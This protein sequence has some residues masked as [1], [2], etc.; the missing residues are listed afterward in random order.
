[1]SKKHPMTEYFKWGI[2]LTLPAALMTFLFVKT[3][4]G[5]F[6]VF[7]LGLGLCVG[8]LFLFRLINLP[9]S[10]EEIDAL[11]EEEIIKSVLRELNLLEK[12]ALVSKNGRV[13][14]ITEKLVANGTILC[15]LLSSDD[16]QSLTLATQI[17]KLIKLMVAQLMESNRLALNPDDEIYDGFVSAAKLINSTFT[18]MI[19]DY[20]EGRLSELEIAWSALETEMAMKGYVLPKEKK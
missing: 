19:E 20:R 16:F 7:L 2:S 3:N 18:Q 12:E 4:G 10:K 11:T 9:T 13:D 1:M 5:F 6:F 17:R 15:R 14:N 8:L